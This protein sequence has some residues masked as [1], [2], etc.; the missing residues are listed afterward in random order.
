MIKYTT[1]ENDWPNDNKAQVFCDNCGAW[2]VAGVGFSCLLEAC[3]HA[4]IAGFTGVTIGMTRFNPKEGHLCPA[5]AKK[6]TVAE[7]E[8][9]C[10]PTR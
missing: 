9:L 4:S 7:M 5:C 8:S 1:G 2:A 10:S 6:V 3:R